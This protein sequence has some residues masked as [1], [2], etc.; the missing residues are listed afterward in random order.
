MFKIPG[1]DRWFKW[2]D[3]N[4]P[5]CRYNLSLSALPFP[6]LERA[7]IETS[8]DEFL[9][10]GE[11]V[12]S[13]YVTALS[14]FLGVDED[15]ILPLGSASQAIYIAS[16]HMA[17]RVKSVAIP[18]PEYEPIVSV[19]ETLGLNV[20]FFDLNAHNVPEESAVMCSS[21]N[22]PAGIK[23]EWIP[24]LVTDINNPKLIDETFLPFMPDFGSQFRR[25][26][27][28]ICA[29]TTTKYFGLGDVRSGWIVADPETVDELER[30]T[31]QVSPGVSGY[32]L[33][34]GSQAIESA[35]YFRKRAAEVMGRNLDLVDKF[36]SETSGLSWEKPDA[37]PYGF[38]KFN[39]GK[40]E[41]LCTRILHETGVL[42]VP[43]LYMGDDSGFRLCFTSGHEELESALEALSVF[44][45]GKHSF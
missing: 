23:P 32:T 10:I 6:D 4:S 8:M 43:G 22:N 18:L 20:S 26:S 7:G 44:F 25:N 2:I 27:D 15:C 9:K 36:V 45:A 13:R 29:G 31:E 42:V 5:G 37:A 30:I 38:I 41:E 24:D 3:D 35:E 17:S 39:G 33:W 19:P 14:G 34:I 16:F 28:V 12:N 11:E 1:H 40:S 21:P